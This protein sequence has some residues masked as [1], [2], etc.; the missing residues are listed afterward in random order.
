MLLNCVAQSRLTS[1]VVKKKKKRKRGKKRQGSTE[2][3]E[4]ITGTDGLL[5]VRM[6]YICFMPNRGDVP[7]TSI[8][9]A[10]F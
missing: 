8:R 2:G 9:L 10:F 7:F 1:S 6:T 4:E 5:L 3:E